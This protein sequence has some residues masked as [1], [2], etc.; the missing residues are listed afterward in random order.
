MWEAEPALR[1]VPGSYRVALVVCDDVAGGWTNRYSC[2]YTERLAAPPPP[3]VLVAP[4][5]PPYWYGPRPYYH[6]RVYYRIR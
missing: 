5:P 6:G 1:D 3:A 2:E 4:G